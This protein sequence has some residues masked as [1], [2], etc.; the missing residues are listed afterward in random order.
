MKTS[1][2]LLAATV[3]GLSSIQAASAA[4]EIMP[5]DA[6]Y[7]GI[8]AGEIAGWASVVAPTNG[9]DGGDSCGA[10]GGTEFCATVFG[11]G[12]YGGVQFAV[13]PGWSVI[14][15]G[16]FD[17]HD[18]TNSSSGSRNDDAVYGALGVHLVTDY[19]PYDVGVFGTAIWA[20]AHA[21]SDEIRGM[22]GAGAEVRRDNIFLQGGALFSTI[23]EDENIDHMFFIRGGGEYEVGPGV[24]EASAA[25]GF[26]DFDGSNGGGDERD[27]SDWVQWA[28]QYE[29]PIPNTRANWFAGYQGDFVR[30]NEPSDDLE[31]AIFHT[32]ML[33]VK[34][35][36]NGNRL[37]FKTPNFRAPIVNADEMN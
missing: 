20:S 8:I 3:A 13:T 35:K 36:L 17:Y 24:I 28:I 7:S 30:V 25:Y 1:Q 14:V 19:G 6:S 29:A 15:D 22:Y 9:L 34:V 16:T 33:G 4:D 12:A 5:A 21:T 11:G 32:F 18:E 23:V 37:P 2:L 27:D 10:G 26:G 31:R